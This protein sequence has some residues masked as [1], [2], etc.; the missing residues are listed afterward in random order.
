M[1]IK[2]Q[3]LYLLI[4]H[5]CMPKKVPTMSFGLFLTNKNIFNMKSKH[6]KN[7]TEI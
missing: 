3:P 1:E 5:Y 4:G 2:I 6:W 7:R